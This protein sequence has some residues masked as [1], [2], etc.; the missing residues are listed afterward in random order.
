MGAKWGRDSR[1][2][3]YWYDADTGR[4]RKPP[5]DVERPRAYRKDKRGRG[6]WVWL[7]TG[8]R[9]GKP[10][11]DQAPRY[12]RLGRP[13]DSTGRRVPAAALQ[14]ESVLAPLPETPTGAPRRK[15]AATPVRPRL[16]ARARH[17]I[18]RADQDVPGF[19][20]PG[21][22]AYFTRPTQTPPRDLDR[23]FRRWVQGAVAKSPFSGPDEIGFRQ[24]GVVF[25]VTAPLD[26]TALAELTNKL[27]GQPVRIVFRTVG[28]NQWEIWTHLNRP[29][30]RTKA[31]E[32]KGDRAVER[33][34]KAATTATNIIY[35][36]LEDWDAD[37]AWYEYIETD[38]DLYEG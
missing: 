37:F 25:T 6:Y 12:D 24:H 26:T 22:G 30:R 31:I 29:D 19:H 36:F 2:R 18:R 34:F 23:I 8:Q 7:D 15:K 9:S 4:R 21:G 10:P 14:A 13:L 32:Q 35:D 17:Q 16:P 33:S 5:S 20:Q 1:G 27:E 3:L 38:D 11:W 28:R